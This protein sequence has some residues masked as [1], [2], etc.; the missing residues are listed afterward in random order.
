MPLCP[1]R[2]QAPLQ[3]VLHMALTAADTAGEPSAEQTAEALEVAG[4]QPRRTKLAPGLHVHQGVVTLMCGLQ[5]V[6][7]ANSV[8]QSLPLASLASPLA[9][10]L[11]L[12]SFTL[13]IFRHPHAYWSNRWVGAWGK[14][15][16]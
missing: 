15:Q 8:K 11:L 5:V 13:L 1:L 16:Q 6:S 12:L 14:R 4:Q 2:V 9:V 10:L 3:A 7:V